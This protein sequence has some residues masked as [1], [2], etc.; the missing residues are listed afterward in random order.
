MRSLL[1][2]TPHPVLSRWSN[3]EE[4]DWRSM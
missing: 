2:C 1:I 4:W 3:Q